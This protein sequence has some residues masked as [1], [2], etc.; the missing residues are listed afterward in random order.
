MDKEAEPS[1]EDGY[2]NRNSKLNKLNRI[3]SGFINNEQTEEQNKPSL[4][5]YMKSANE[6]SGSAAAFQPQT[7]VDNNDYNLGRNT[8]MILDFSNQ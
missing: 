8:K 3:D 1:K 2:N 5:F 7:A 4:D 6:P